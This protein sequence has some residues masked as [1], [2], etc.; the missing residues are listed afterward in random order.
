MKTIE[1]MKVRNARTGITV[2]IKP[3]DVRRAGV[4]NPAKCAVAQ[5]LCRDPAMKAARVHISRTYVQP[6]GADHWLRYGTPQTLRTE[7]IAFDKGAPKAFKD[8]H[9]FILPP[10]KEKWST[11][12]QQGSKR[13]QT[14]RGPKEKRTYILTDIRPNALKEFDRPK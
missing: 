9:T 13:S 2:T 3:G 4:Q 1:G 12:K 5:A 14:K 11:G 6:R 8:E 10:A 7:I